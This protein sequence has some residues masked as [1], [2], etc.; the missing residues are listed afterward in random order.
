MPPR[1]LIDCCSP[2]VRPTL[3]AAQAVELERLFK[4]VA[5]RHRVQILNLLVGA[6]D[7]VCVCKL[8]PALGLAQ[9]TVSYHLKLLVDAGLLERERRGRFSYY[10]LVAGALD[11]LGELVCGPAVVS[12]RAA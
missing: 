8:M 2:L 9:P 4:A 12:D 3:T 6:E 5:D 11:R 10:R 1:S 7:A